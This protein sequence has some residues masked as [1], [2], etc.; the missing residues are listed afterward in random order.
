MYDGYAF[1]FEKVAGVNLLAIAEEE[2]QGGVFTLDKFLK[3]LDTKLQGLIEY[4]EKNMG[5]YTK[6][7]VVD[8]KSVDAEGSTF[9]KDMWNNIPGTNQATPLIGRKTEDGE[10][11]PG[12]LNLGEKQ[13]QRIVNDHKGINSQKIPMK[14]T[15]ALMKPMLAAMIVE[16]LM[17][18]GQNFVSVTDVQALKWVL[19][20]KEPSLYTAKRAQARY[21]SYSDA[22]NF[23]EEEVQFMINESNLRLTS[24]WTVFLKQSGAL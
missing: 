20:G 9:A 21:R 8:Q 24:S 7:L 17:R 19:C 13:I 10:R 12:M 3:F 15:R 22:F 23:T 4:V 14:L 2:N 1:G 16:T 6:A 5:Y 11:M 18:S